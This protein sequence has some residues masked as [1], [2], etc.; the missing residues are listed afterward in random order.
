[1]SPALLE[2]FSD[3]PWLSLPDEFRV[4]KEYV[5]FLSLN[6]FCEIGFGDKD[7]LA[8]IAELPAR[9]ENLVS[10]LQDFLEISTTSDPACQ[11]TDKGW[12]FYL[13]PTMNARRGVMISASD[14]E[15]EIQALYDDSDIEIE[16]IDGAPPEWKPENKIAYKPSQEKA[17]MILP[18]TS[19]SKD[20]PCVLPSKRVERSRGAQMKALP[21]ARP[22]ENA[23]RKH[24]CLSCYLR[25]NRKRRH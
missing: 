23:Q 3:K 8:G 13:K 10:D 18:F 24:S 9:I 1:M 17:P 25:R 5:R 12:E 11:K 16:V 14:T 15:K 21:D 4:N 20:N 22:E 7:S 6:E 19:L 2:A